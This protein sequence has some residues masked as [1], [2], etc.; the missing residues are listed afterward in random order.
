MGARARVDGEFLAG[1]SPFF[2]AMNRNKK[3][4]TLDLKHQ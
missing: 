2:Y 3:S 1:D 4:L